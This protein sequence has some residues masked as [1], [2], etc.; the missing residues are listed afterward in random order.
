MDTIFEGEK[1][2]KGC[3]YRIIFPKFP[4]RN[5]GQHSFRQW[6][7]ARHDDEPRRITK[8][9]HHVD[10]GMEQHQAWGSRGVAATREQT[11]RQTRP[12]TARSHRTNTRTYSRRVLHAPFAQ[13]MGMDC[14]AIRPPATALTRQDRKVASFLVWML[15]SSIAELREGR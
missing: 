15:S 7:R 5:V 8:S 12:T 9:Q 10:R 11:L 2:P 1:R 6:Q 13:T 14:E 3:E 4:L